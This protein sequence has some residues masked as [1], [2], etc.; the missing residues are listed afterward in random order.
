MKIVLGE[1]QIQAR[2]RE[3]AEKISQ[4]YD[5]EVVHAVGILENGFMFL[6]DLVR[7]MT[8]PVV[9]HFLKMETVDTASEGHQP[10]RNILYGPVGEVG[11]KNLLLVDAMVDSGIT[12]DHLIQQLQLKKPK[13]LRT[14]ALL[15]REDRRRV[16]L[17]LDYTGFPWSGGHLVGYGLEK[18]GRYRNL[19]YIA[20]IP[21]DGN[22]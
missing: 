21:P 6:A 12:L 7:K 17:V 16:P 5:G 15:D 9:C 8:C 2:V 10:R 4:D 18:D 3:M 19:P 22:G 11:G 1:E 13:S 20:A 14:V